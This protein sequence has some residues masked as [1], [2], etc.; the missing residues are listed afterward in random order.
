M[1]RKIGITQRFNSE[2]TK[3]PS[4]DYYS[5]KVEVNKPTYTEPL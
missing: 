1:Y 4:P 5:S 2:D 3:Q